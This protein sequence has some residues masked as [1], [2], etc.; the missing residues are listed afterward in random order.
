M[1]RG[2]SGC[3][4]VLPQPAHAHIPPCVAAE[5]PTTAQGLH[6]LHGLGPLSEADVLQCHSCFCLTPPALM[7]AK[8]R[9][10]KKPLCLPAVHFPAAWGCS[11]GSCLHS[12]L[13]LSLGKLSLGKLC[14][15]HP[16]IAA[17][18]GVHRAWYGE[19]LHFHA[20]STSHGRRARKA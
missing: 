4:V 11:V 19:A 9:A 13:C 8:S 5:V 7:W 14:S 10:D 20:G 18:H 1:L 3:G 2:S 16:P 6:F 12:P 15:K 17:V